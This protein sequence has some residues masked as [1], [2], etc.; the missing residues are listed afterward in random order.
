MRTP[1]HTQVAKLAQHTE[2]LG[3]DNDRLEGLVATLTAEK[4][5]L[6]EAKVS[7]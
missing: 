2:A 1:P 3:V 6:L 4:Q 7:C 5:A